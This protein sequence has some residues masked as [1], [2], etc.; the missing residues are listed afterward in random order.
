M[1]DMA[2]NDILLRQDRPLTSLSVYRGGVWFFTSPTNLTK[3]Y[4]KQRF[5]LMSESFGLVKQG[6]TDPKVLATIG[7]PGDYIAVNQD[8][9]YTL[10]SSTEYKRL[11]PPPN[12]NPPEIPNNSDQ[13]KDPK[14]LTN[15]LKGSGSPASNSKTSKPTP[16]NTGY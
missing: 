12:L 9:T 5:Y 3:T 13:L 10:V 4:N 16:P 7:L 11:F 2:L 6:N 8:G 1:K 15:I 14:F